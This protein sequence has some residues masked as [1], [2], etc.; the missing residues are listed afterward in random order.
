MELETME[1]NYSC[2]LMLPSF[3]GSPPGT[4]YFSLFLPLSPSA[5]TAWV[6][7]LILK[8]DE[9]TTNNPPVGGISKLS[10][11]RCLVR[12]GMLAPREAQAFLGLWPGYLAQALM[13]RKEE[14]WF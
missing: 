10:A 7:S 12:A 11:G 2:F 13:D 5:P 8:N 4:F 1:V 6:V 3:K 9:F 14:Q